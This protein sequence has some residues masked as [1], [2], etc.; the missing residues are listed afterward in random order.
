[1]FF[2]FILFCVAVCY[3]VQA[4]E[5]DCPEVMALMAFIGA[6]ML[7]LVTLAAIPRKGIAIPQKQNGT[8]CWRRN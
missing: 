5:D 6:F 7:L 8:R 4:V 2:Y 3:G 1:M